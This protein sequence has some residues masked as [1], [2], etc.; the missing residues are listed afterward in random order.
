MKTIDHLIS[1]ESVPATSG[2]TSPV[3]DPA[4]GEQTAE[5]GLASVDDVDAA[6][7][8]AASAFEDWRDVSIAKR[9]KLMFAFRELVDRTGDEIAK[10]LTAEHGKV[11]DDARGEVARGLENIEYACGLAELLKGS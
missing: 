7:A 8:A 2:R 6:I 11:L 4:T 9:T 10:R 1:G 5:L 3:F